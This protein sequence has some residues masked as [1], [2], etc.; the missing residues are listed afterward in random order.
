MLI[1]FIKLNVL[2][3]K[4]RNYF[5]V[6]EKYIKWHLTTRRD[7]IASIK[8]AVRQEANEISTGVQ[9]ERCECDQTETRTGSARFIKKGRST[10]SL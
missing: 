7:K 1:A 10:I 3:I 2:D 4:D 5:Y 6:L 8:T 9:L